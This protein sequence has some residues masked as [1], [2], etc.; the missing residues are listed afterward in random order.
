MGGIG[1]IGARPVFAAPEPQTNAAATLKGKKVLFVYGGWDGHE[2][3]PSRDL[4]VPWLKEEGADVKVSD[5]LDSYL[6][7]S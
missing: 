5:N 7:E 1:L 6:Y 2:P 4:F 3:V